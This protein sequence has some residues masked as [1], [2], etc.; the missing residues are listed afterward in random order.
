M[1][2]KEK[3]KKNKTVHMDGEHYFKVRWTG[4]VIPL[5]RSSL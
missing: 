1:Y 2:N 5:Y 4:K 3:L